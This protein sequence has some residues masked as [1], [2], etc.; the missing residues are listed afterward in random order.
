MTDF[1]NTQFVLSSNL[2]SQFN[3]VNFINSQNQN[4]SSLKIFFTK[5]TFLNESLTN[6]SLNLIKQYRWLTK[7]YLNSSQLNKNSN[8]L[9]QSKSLISDP[10]NDINILDRN[11]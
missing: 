6:Q 3:N 1:N 2:N 5:Y 9:T 4:V 10:L 8:N 11:V 7:N